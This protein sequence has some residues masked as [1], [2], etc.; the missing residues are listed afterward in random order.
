MIQLRYFGGLGNRLFQYCTGRIIAEELNLTLVAPGI[1]GFPRTREKVKGDFVGPRLRNPRQ[2]VKGFD[3]EI[4]EILKDRTRRFIRLDGACSQN[5][6]RDYIP[7]VA[8]MREW[9][10]PQPMEVKYP[11]GDLVVAHVRL[12]DYES[13]GYTLSEGFYRTILGDGPGEGDRRLIVVTD[14]PQ[15]QYLEMFKRWE[16]IIIST[17]EL[18]DFSFLLGA[19]TLIMSASTFSWWAAFLG[20]Q[21]TVYFPIP[22]RGYWSRDEFE[23]IDL[24]LPKEDPRYIYVGDS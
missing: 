15:S 10:V 9:C 16:A 4:S 14:R 20:S 12:G 8:K 17:S 24:V 2:K 19:K 1:P 6:R 5:F 21:E 13:R 3:L 11:S 7:Y 23:F 18:N 22:K